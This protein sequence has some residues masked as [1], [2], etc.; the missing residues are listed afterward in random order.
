MATDKAVPEKEFESI[1]EGFNAFN[2][3]IFLFED[4]ANA[5]QTTA[6]WWVENHA[7]DWISKGVHTEEEAK[8]LFEA[9]VA[10]AH[11]SDFR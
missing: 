11:F 9:A 2:E 7:T 1:A 4:P 8:A 6:T 5:I 10:N 3:P